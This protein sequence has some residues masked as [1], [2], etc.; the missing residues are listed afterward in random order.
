MGSDVFVTVLGVV[1][2][3]V[4]G[5]P[6]DLGG[7]Q[8]R[9]LLAALA[10]DWAATVGADRLIDRVWSSGDLPSDP[11]RT[12]RTYLTRLRQA[13]GAT[14][15]IVTAE[16]GWHLN[17]T[18]VSVDAA[19]LV[20]L[21]ELTSDPGL[22]AHQ[23]LA[24]I[25]EALTLYRGRPYGDLADEEWLRGEVDRL[26]ELRVS[27]VERRYQAMLDAG[28]HTDAVPG[29]AAEVEAHPLRDRLVGLQ[30]LAL[31]RTGRQAEASRVFQQHRR[32]LA[33]DLG[34][35]PGHEL[36]DL[37]RRVLAGDSS[38]HLTASSG[39]A[40]RGYRLG[41]QLG[42]GAFAI[43]YRGTQPTL[44][45]D[46]AVKIIR[47]ELAN[48]P[49]FI[50]RFEAEAHLVARLEH[51]RIVPL[52]DYWREP[53][54]A[55]LVFRYLR[56]GTL[57][58]RLTQ[59]GP[60]DLDAAARLVDHVGAA[61]G[62]AHASGVVH[63][64]VKPANVFIDDE[65]NFYL[66][67]FGIAL[68]AAKLSD[69]TAA[70]SAGSPA[71]ASPEQLRRE[72][73][74]PTADVYGLGI[75][76]YEALTAQLP[77]PD[78]AS[79]ADL[80]QRQLNE[81]IPRVQRF[82]SD[83]PPAIDDVL[84]RATAKDPSGRIQ[85]VE[86]LVEN[87]GHAI[88]EAKGTRAPTIR[89]GASTAVSGAQH[90]NPY[91]GLRAFTEADAAEF[92]GRERLVDRLV[93]LLGR[94]NNTGRIAAVVGPS[95]IGKSSVVRA[96]LLPAVRQGAVEGSDRWF[97]AT[98]RPGADPFE[99]LATAL[100]RVATRTPDD[101]MGLLSGDHRG[102]A[103]V[104]KVLIPEDSDAEVLLFIDQFEELFTLVDDNRVR[105]LFL[106]SLVHAVTDARC[107]V[108][109]VLTIRA[110][111]WDQPLRYGSFARLIDDSTVHVTAL[112][113]DELERAIVE[114]A[115]ALSGEFEPGL[116]SEIAADVTDEPG[117]LPLLQ[118]ALTELWE[119]HVSGLL[120]RDAYR[121]LGGV[122][123]ALAYR[124]EE[125]Y[126]RA[127]PDERT[128]IQ[129]VM[130][131]L[132][133][134]GDATDDS[135]RRARRAEFVA[136]PQ[137]E[138]T[139]E[140]FGNARLLSF[141][142]EP[143]SREPTVELAHEALIHRWPRLQSW[144]DE[145][146]T[147]L[148]IHRH[149]GTTAQAWVEAGRDED[150]LYRGGRLETAEEWAVSH[151]DELDDAERDFLE[152]SVGRRQGE[153]AAA[154]R[155]H[156]RL[157]GSLAA[158]AIVAALALVAGIVAVQQRNRANDEAD[159]A[160]TQAALAAERAG[161]AEAATQQAVL[162]QAEAERTAREAETGR[163]VATAQSLSGS[164]SRVAMLL[165]TI[166]HQRDE[167]PATLGA[168]LT[169]LSTADGLVGHVRW[170]VPY[171]DVEWLANGHIVG[172]GAGSIDL[173]DGS[174]WALMDSI[175]WSLSIEASG[176]VN[177]VNIGDSAADSSRF[178][179]IGDDRELAFFE[180]NGSLVPLWERQL[181]S[182]PLVV[183]VR[184]DGDSVVAVDIGQRVTAYSGAGAEL[185]SIDLEDAANVASQVGP[186]V[187]D[188]EGLGRYFETVPVLPSVEATEAGPIVVSGS[189]MRRLDW[190]GQVI[191]QPVLLLANGGPGF[192]NQIVPTPN[193]QID[194][195]GFS[196]LARFSPSTFDGDVLAT[197]VLEGTRGGGSPNVTTAIAED[198]G[199][200]VLL[201][202]GSL[203]QFDLGGRRTNLVAD[204]GLGEARGGMSTSPDGLNTAVA[205]ADGLSVVSL[206]DGRPLARGLPR[207]PGAS[208]LSTSADGNTVV[209]GPP[210]V[211]GPVEIWNIDGTPDQI[212]EGLPGPA[213]WAAAGGEFVGFS[214]ETEDARV[215]DLRRTPE[216]EPIYRLELPGI[217]G[218]N[219]TAVSVDR[220][221]AA[222]GAGSPSRVVVFTL[223]GGEVI[224]ELPSPAGDP[225][226]A[227][228]STMFDPATERL[229]VAD[230]R[231]NAVIYETDTWARL[232]ME[233]LDSA[234]IAVANWNLDGSL[235]ATA[236]ST[237]DIV[238]RDGETFEVIQRMTGAVGT[239]NSFGAGSLFFTADDRFLLTNFDGPGRLWDLGSGQ[240]VGIDLVT[241]QG[242]LSGADHDRDSDVLRL[243]TGTNR[244]LLVWNLDVRTWP[245][246]A[247]TAA[248][249]D[250]TREEWDQWGPRDE[251]YRELCNQ[252]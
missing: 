16:E 236:S 38:L 205:H 203:T 93:K 250:L 5:K 135:R 244:S 39:Q 106:D 211:V 86:E 82:R 142:T 184:G 165:A 131:R 200:T 209:A 174:T 88:D 129:A 222:W 191:G 8:Q 148:W 53:D 149:L 109:V 20:R 110:D 227:I 243:V 249:S 10:V 118:Y 17:P 189:V 95:G 183:S 116:V 70:L 64:D 232:D 231:G 194:L 125:L 34:L 151:A 45:R 1:G 139:I 120:T 80:L 217:V 245:H 147:G 36:V 146:R 239:A 77:F 169:S 141:D 60:L 41:E 47:S 171:L 112:A 132:V 66:G 180:A 167:S 192:A 54:R 56:G 138:A 251:P 152:A 242:T 78:A 241:S 218:A 188:A 153:M 123:G 48:Q 220:G 87:L 119:R 128:I 2:A 185:Y 31:F 223:D 32:R 124:A 196:T 81:P 18:L 113:A 85:T 226:R 193:G 42:E 234:D 61:L 30:M 164:N 216:L 98:M 96:G 157:R 170:G 122:A 248:G 23:R 198:S 206:Y 233:Q 97:V 62:A 155:S 12:L 161:D 44:G 179:V 163:L 72:P 83:L 25:D 58:A 182:A 154:R 252:S 225:G 202:D 208:V 105:R 21:V 115:A 207:N 214:I 90:R 172:I 73:I 46:V 71:Y 40:L 50:R 67:D 235:V 63:R 91:K 69:P 68:E 99:E 103:R 104:V 246:I 29:L 168:L 6:V 65:D 35:T 190:D 126:E 75:S 11:R 33:K 213:L 57:E 156:R 177:T 27:L 195:V 210:G 228:T 101:L 173:F 24:T 230:A 79:Q 121:D 49:E 240:Q 117:A 133:A 19:D 166:A 14:D 100:L 212:E 127:T 102:I 158:V 15:T 176:F 145:D 3:K 137:A 181:Q 136:T 89:R 201:S 134:P 221:I 238:V 186:A 229:L 4:H 22:N 219:S 160:K 175:P 187:A 7:P 224:V 114:P 51:P 92:H 26:E 159:Q 107:P 204:V 84:A 28:K 74:G 178:A 199:T 59:S 140:R 13:L 237:G 37:D 143:R 197:S 162:A 215:F 55:C 144:L 52:Y 43:V 9:R 76:L 150:E 247:C 94:A 130:K 111:Y 108:R